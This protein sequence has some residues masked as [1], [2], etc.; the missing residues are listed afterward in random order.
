MIFRHQSY[1][2][3]GYL[4]TVKEKEFHVKQQKVNGMEIKQKLCSTAEAMALTLS[5][6]SFLATKKHPAKHRCISN[7][8]QPAKLAISGT[9]KMCKH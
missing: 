1:H 6:K 2:L 3:F 5:P 7:R 4:L 8:P 9:Q